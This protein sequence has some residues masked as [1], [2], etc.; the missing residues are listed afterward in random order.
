MIPSRMLVL[1]VGIS[2]MGHVTLIS[3]A[4]FIGLFSPPLM[5]EVMKIELSDP[6]RKADE[7]QREDTRDKQRPAGSG[8][9]DQHRRE[10]T[11]DL[12]STSTRYAQY[13]ARLRKQIEN[14]WEYPPEAYARKERGTAVLQF[15]IAEDGTLTACRVVA[16]SGF[17]ALD[18]GAVDV[19][20]TAAPYAPLPESFGLTTLHV[21]ARFQYDILR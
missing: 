14:R 17:E 2:L 15:S 13:L 19:V 20:K 11:V 18:S 7:V 6:A 4:G 8:S 5:E 12:G 21:L 3:A 10:D 1:F 16:S 9:V